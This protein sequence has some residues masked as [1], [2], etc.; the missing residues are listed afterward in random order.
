MAGLW[1]KILRVDL[2]SLT[3]TEENIP[4]SWGKKFLGG[5]GLA[6][7]YLIDEVPEGCDP[8]GPLN[9]LIFMTGPLTGTPSPS[10]GRYNVVSKSPLTGIWAQ[11]NAGGFWGPSF[12]GNG[13]DGIIF[14]GVSSNP[15]YLVIE[16]G[17]PELREAGDVWGKNVSETTRMLKAELG[18]EFEVSCIGIA[19]EKLVKYACV[20][21]NEHRVAGRCGLG[22]VMGS[23]RLKAVAVR[24]T[25]QTPIANP[26]V[27]AQVATR[28]YE[29]LNESFL[30]IGLECYGTAMGLEMMNARG[31]FPTRNFQTGISPHAEAISGTVLTEKLLTDRLSCAACPIACGRVVEIKSG[32]YAG[33]K[34]EG[35]E[36]ESLATFGGMCDIGDIE[37]I[38]VA[39]NLCDDYGIDSI[40]TGVS[41]AFAME[42]YEKG[43]LTKADTEGLELIWG[44]VSVTL[45]LV[46]KIGNREGFGDFLAEGTRRM[47]EKLGRGSENFAMHVKGLELPGY[48]PRG[49]KL[50]GLAYATANRGADHMTSSMQIP[51]IIIDMPILIVEYTHVED[52]MV[53][54]PEEV[55]ILTSLEDACSLF[56]STGACKFMGICMSYEEWIQLIASVTGYDF[57]FEDYKMTGERIYNL[58]RIFSVREGITRADDT[59]PKRL[60][61]EP[62]P[63]GPAKGHVNKLDILLDAYYE[64]RGWD[65]DG[66]PTVERLNQLGLE[67]MTKIVG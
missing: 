33:M 22:A 37:A 66:R 15:V 21:N 9:K 18:E 41:I 62:L 45:D 5:S 3:V 34:G 43:I 36:Y 2:D 46:H 24:G 48:E 65:S 53:E 8:L 47:S 63:E 35:P 64:I 60:L 67:E 31:A 58:A 17:K 52:P 6:T 42:C 54:N 12:K 26:S 40:S 27:F 16:E 39:H 10:S 25:K 14:Q 19:G 30:K 38:A 13:F 61:E 32:P 44:N 50:M 51:G 28:N 11:A 49:A 7:R 56:D 4:E 23:K 55:R 57:T 59:L 29:L 20:V 1:G